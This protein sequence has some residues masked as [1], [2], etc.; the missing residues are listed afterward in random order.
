MSGQWWVLQTNAVIFRKI[1][2]VL[3]QALIPNLFSN[4]CHLGPHL[5][6]ISRKAVMEIEKTCKMA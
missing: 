3:L 4:H 6:V 5:Y 2:M 1:I